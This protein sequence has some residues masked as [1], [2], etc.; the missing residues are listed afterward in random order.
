MKK[1]I[2]LTETELIRI[3][4]KVIKENEITELG[5][6]DFT[7]IEDISCVKPKGGLY[8]GVSTLSGESKFKPDSQFIVIYYMEGDKKVVYG[9]GPEVT[10]DMI[11][12]KDY[13]EKPI[14][15]RI[16]QKTLSDMAKE[17]KENL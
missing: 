15:C 16:A 17:Y 1:I 7:D 11:D 5:Q 9:Y 4:K 8:A 14:I 13:Q 12:R 2:K 10:E 3:I 6:G